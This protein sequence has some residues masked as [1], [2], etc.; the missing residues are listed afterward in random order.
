MPE[1]S[2][3]YK[4]LFPYDKPRK[5]QVTGIKRIQSGINDEAIITMEGACGTGKTLTALIPY[6]DDVRNPK[7][8]SERVVIV[9]SVKQQMEAFQD[10]IRRINNNL[11]DNVRSV[12]AI[13]LVSVSDL[14]PYMDQDLIDSYDEIDSLRE[15]TRNLVD[16]DIHNYTYADLASRVEKNENGKYMYD[17]YI[18]TADGIEY[19]PYYAK[20]RS[21]YDSDED[22]AEEVLPFDPTQSGLMNVNKLRNICGKNGY[23]P[24]SMMRI[25]I[26]KVDVVIGN[27]MHIFDE[28]TVTRVSEPIIDDNTFAIFDEAHNLVP[29]VREFLSLSSSITSINKSIYEIDEIITLYKLSNMNKEQIQNIENSIIQGGNEVET[30]GEVNSDIG[31]NIRNLI[32]ES[33]IV[34]KPGDFYKNSKKIK[35]VMSDIDINIAEFEDYKKMLEELRDVIYNQVENLDYIR[36][37]EKIQL[38]DPENPQDDKITEWTQLSGYIKTMKK[39][40]LIGNSCSVI[41]DNLTDTS[42]KVKTS[43]RPVGELLT[44]WV[45]FDN[46]RYYRSIDLEERHQTSSYGVRDW[47]SDIKAKLRINNCIPRNEIS[48][49]LDI[50]KSSV[51]MSAT[52]EPMDV[53]NKT[54]GI[55]KLED[56]GRKVIK[57]SFGLAF[58]EKNRLTIGITADKFKY[59]NRGQPFNNYG[60]IT[61]TPTR[62]QYRD[63]LFD[64]VNSTP[65][66]VLIVMPSYK[67]AEWIG[68]L[69]EQSYMCNADD[70]FI[71][72]SSSNQETDRLKEAFFDSDDGVLVTGARGTLIEG[73]DYIEDRLKATVVCGVPITNT[74]SDYKKAI[75]AAYDEIFRDMN[76]FTLAFSIPAVWK[77]RQAIGR[78]IR[79]KNDIGTRILVDKRYV[80]SSLWDSVHEF[81]SPSERNEIKPIP[82]KD[83]EIRL[84]SFWDTKED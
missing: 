2:E 38:R 79:T 9:T 5:S 18:P 56:E 25:A 77:A 24:H 72:Q 44:S 63:I 19:D 49:R 14:H 73:V 71:D 80:D 84:E 82:P 27:Y 51:L 15:G 41:R 1:L 47:Q 69:L 4:S 10:E 48:Q 61:D 22:N 3:K 65:G 59:Q 68:S 55:Q 75:Q 29:K 17:S 70:I 46:I 7:T 30:G 83:T 50:F 32:G 26:D 42:D 45:E 8:D 52:L 62:E 37:G 11:S 81:L 6:L 57:C 76:G 54:T 43:S 21:E 66:N 33:A 28:K 64:V 39:G 13:T 53:Y 35:S 67:E 60:P 16:K 40:K 20:Y 78:V 31:E 74:N 58:P 36:D 34:T 12:S 23:C